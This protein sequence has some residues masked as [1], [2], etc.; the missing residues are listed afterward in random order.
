MRIIYTEDNELNEFESYNKGYRNDVIV[1]IQEK[2]YYLNI[3]DY[4]RLSQDYDNETKNGGKYL[5][6]P[7]LIIVKE[8]TKAEIE[9]TIIELEKIGFFRK[10]GGLDSLE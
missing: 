5:N 9:E 10:L 6:V 3:I 4:N 7:N 8:V 2:K 1:I